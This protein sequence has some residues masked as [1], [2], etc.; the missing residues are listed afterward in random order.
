[1]MKVK[2]RKFPTSL[3]I[4]Y[5]SFSFDFGRMVCRIRNILNE[6]KTLHFHSGTFKS[7]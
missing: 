7:I 2:R 1:M 4:E 5:D 6:I 3:Y